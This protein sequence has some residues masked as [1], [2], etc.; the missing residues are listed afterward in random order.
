[1]F[2]QKEMNRLKKYLWQRTQQRPNENKILKRRWE[3]L[4]HTL[5]KPDSNIT[6]QA[7]TWNPQGKRNRGRPRNTWRRDLNKHVA[8]TGMGWRRLV[9]VAQDRGRWRESSMAYLPGGGMG[10]KVR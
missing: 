1:M 7:L 6:K 8:E 3:W 2:Q 4:G 10:H 9:T 5:R